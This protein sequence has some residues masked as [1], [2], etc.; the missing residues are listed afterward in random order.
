VAAVKARN[1]KM[2]VNEQHQSHLITA[3]LDP[4]NPHYDFDAL[5][6]TARTQGFTI[7]PGKLGNINT[8]RIAN[9]GDIQPDEM[10]R[11]TQILG[12]Y[13]DRIG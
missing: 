5:H 3:I 10:Q 9:I 13:L 6:D 2:L 7:Y 11:F 8:F 12:E 4:E 1:L